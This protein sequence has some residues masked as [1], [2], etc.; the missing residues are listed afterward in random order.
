MGVS[1]QQLVTAISQAMSCLCVGD[2]KAQP[3]K[4]DG[5]NKF[6]GIP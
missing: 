3:S 1:P 5:G 4:T 6:M 2:K